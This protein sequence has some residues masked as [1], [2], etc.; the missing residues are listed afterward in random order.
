MIYVLSPNAQQ[1]E[2]LLAR[3]GVDS[4]SCVIATSKEDLRGHSFDPTNDKV[5][6]IEGHDDVLLFELTVPPG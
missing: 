3:R 1:A 4:D 5:W 6:T 2:S